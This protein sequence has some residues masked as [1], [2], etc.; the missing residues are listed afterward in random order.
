MPGVKGYEAR[1]GLGEESTWGTPVACTEQLRFNTES[2]EESSE[3]LVSDAI[4]GRP[5]RSIETL[6][7]IRVGGTVSA[8]LRYPVAGAAVP[9]LLLKHAFGQQFGVLYRNI[10]NE[11]WVALR[12]GASSNV[13]LAQQIPVPGSGSKTVARV[14]VL[15]RRRGTLS[16][17]TVSVEIRADSAGAPGAVITN[18]T[19]QAVAVN[20]ITT[21][22]FGQWVDFTFAVAPTVTGG[23]IYHIV[24][25]GTYTA[26]ATN[27]L[28]V[29]TED[30]AS[31]GGFEEFDAAWTDVAT[32]NLNARWYAS[33]FADLYPL[34]TKLDGLGLTVAFDKTDAGIFE[35]NGCKVSGLTLRGSPADGCILEASV[36]GKQRNATPT[37]TAAILAGLLNTDP[38]VQFTDLNFRIG[39]QADPL[40]AGDE[41]QI[42]AYELRLGWDLD[43]IN[44]SGGRF[45][46]E[47][48]NTLRTVEFQ[49]TVP[50]FTS[51][52]YHTWQNAGTK[53]QARLAFTNGSRSITILLPNLLLQPSVGAQ[54]QGPQPMTVQVRA[55]AYQNDSNS[56]MRVED[57]LE[58]ALLNV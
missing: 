35:F 20:T 29:G 2:I 16:T 40:A 4:S 38:S 5:S 12:T 54:V 51:Q 53:L 48:L 58:I 22:D 14:R 11:S 32:K 56:V 47:P 26:D 45:I 34:A 57:E 52:Q 49:F 23:T 18:G 33:N 3:P 28:E 41:V 25:F 19:S 17:G 46:I 15:V 27:N 50:R 10:L 44:A 31:G 13:E 8:R 6:G 9:S 36:I 55:T 21:A 24:V 42:S 43:Q 1:C 39:D 37:N 7:P 30:V